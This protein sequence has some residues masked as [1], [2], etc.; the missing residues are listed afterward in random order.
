MRIPKLFFLLLCLM[1]LSSC[2]ARKRAGVSSS[3]TIKD[4]R[5]ESSAE[6][7]QIS[8][9]IDNAQN[10][11]GT[12]YQYGGTTRKGM[13]CSGLIYTAFLMEDIALP[14]TSRDIA[15]LGN[16]LDLGE[17]LEGDLLFFETNKNRRVINHMGL[18][19][20]V[21][22]DVI[23]FIHSTTSRGVIISQLTQ[24]YWREHFVMARRVL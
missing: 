23:H 21:Q 24:N 20:A 6:N 12:A 10:F 3:E 19:V 16:R 22:N 11:L 1:L 14:R 7:P 5:I 18:V 15:L 4:L 9:I 17:V 2:G 8:R 13:D